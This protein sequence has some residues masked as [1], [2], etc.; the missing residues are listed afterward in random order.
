VLATVV[1]P[2]VEAELFDQLARAGSRRS[3]AARAINARR[4]K[5]DEASRSLNMYRDNPRIISQIG[6][7]RFADGL[8]VR[9]HRLDTANRELKAAELTVGTAT[10]PVDRVRE[11]WPTMSM[12]DRRQTIRAAFD[13]VFVGKGRGVGSRM[14]FCLP[15]TRPPDSRQV[16]GPV[17]GLS[18]SSSRGIMNAWLRGGPSAFRGSAGQLMRRF[19][20]ATSRS[21]LRAKRRGQRRAA[22]SKWAGR[23][24]TAAYWP[25][26]ECAGGRRSCRSRITG[27]DGRA[28]GRS[29]KSDES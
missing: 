15:A 17:T 16:A 7:D 29:T 9:Q 27:K 26:G 21:R 14:Y 12:L 4:G 13:C 20:N 19:C 6:S 25:R 1:E 24:S 2:V 18:R 8:T 23:T 10:P 5:R 28:A 22:S 3:S 11:A